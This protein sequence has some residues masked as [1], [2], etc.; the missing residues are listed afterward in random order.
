VLLAIR[1]C[2]VLEAAIMHYMANKGRSTPTAVD[3]REARLC[4]MLCEHLAWQTAEG[5]SGTAG[6]LLSNVSE[7]S[8][9]APSQTTTKDWRV[10]N[11]A[12]AASSPAGPNDGGA[13]DP[14]HSKGLS[15]QTEVFV[16]L[17][18]VVKAASCL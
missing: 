11:T 15:L 4:S 8:A 3:V 7:P 12:R 2:Q 13:G 16:R 17:A 10:R 6:G 9:C 5:G 14:L 1:Q 18:L